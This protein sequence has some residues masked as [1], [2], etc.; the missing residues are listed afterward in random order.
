VAFRVGHPLAGLRYLGRQAPGH[1]VQVG[2]RVPITD[3]EA[4]DIRAHGW[5]ALQERLDEHGLD[6]ADLTRRSVLP[7]WHVTAERS[8]TPSG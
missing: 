4:A 8:G 6:L 2:W 1:S 3:A 7:G 5:P